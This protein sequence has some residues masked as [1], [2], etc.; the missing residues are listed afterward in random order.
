[1]HAHRHDDSTETGDPVTFETPSDAALLARLRAGDPAAE[2]QF[3]DRH[4]DRVY[5]LILRM[6][7]RPELAQ[8]WTQD[9]FLRAFDRLGQF[10]GDAALSSWL[11]AI[12]VSVTLNGLRTLKRREAFAAPLEE[13]TTV[14]ARSTDVGDPDLRTRLKAAIA[15][16]PEGTRRVFLMHD[17][18]GFTHEEISD[19]LGCAIGT[20][21][22]QLSRAR[23]KL[24]HALAAFAPHAPLQLGKESA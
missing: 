18:E 4:V 5:R 16:L 2:R 22:S 3:Y 10:R 14:A 8:E 1:M 19:A 6:S 7:G 17:V 23:E 24:R 9:T 11:H 21:K 13:A 20:S 12:A 15:A